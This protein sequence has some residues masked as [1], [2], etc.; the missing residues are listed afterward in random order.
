MMYGKHLCGE[1]CNTPPRL[2]FSKVLV[3]AATGRTI[4]R[5]SAQ[6]SSPSGIASAAETYLVRRQTPSWGEPHSVTGEH[7]NVKAH[8]P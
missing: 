6:L 3:A 4:G 7:K 1:P 2:P 8:S 5:N